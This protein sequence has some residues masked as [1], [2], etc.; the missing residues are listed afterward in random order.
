MYNLAQLKKYEDVNEMINNVN[1]LPRKFSDCTGY[2]DEKMAKYFGGDRALSEEKVVELLVS[3]SFGANSILYA[4]WLGYLMGM[5]AM[6]IHFAWCMSFYLL[7]KFSKQI[8]AHTSIHDFLSCHFGSVAKKVAAI[9]SCI[10]LL[11]FA[12]WEIAIAKSGLDS[13]TMNSEIGK[14]WVW[15]LLLLVMICI[16]LLYTV[17]GGQ[18]ANGYVNL[19]MNR[20]KVILL[21]V[22]GLGIFYA[23]SNNNQ[24]TYDILMP[25]FKDA[26]KSIGLTGLITNIFINLS[27]QFVDNSSWQIIS[28]GC[29]AGMG[30][31][32]TSLKRTGLQIFLIYA[33][34]TFLGASLRGISGLDSDNVLSGIVYIVGGQGNIFF[35]LCI[36]ILLLLSM[37]SLIDGM[38]LSVAQTIMVDLN[39]G[40][41]IKKIKQNRQSGVRTAR[42]IT[43]FLG[44]LAA[45][46]I[47]FALAGF[48][49]SIFDFVYV[50]TIVQLSL[51]GPII[52]GLV[53]QPRCIPRMWISIVISMTLGFLFNILGN[54]YSISWLGDV[55][56]TVTAISSFAISGL[57]LIVSRNCKK[58]GVSQHMGW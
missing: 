50:F 48:G 9:C 13:F 54:V 42:I 53:F 20:I 1:V 30:T 38:S 18:R 14:S 21:V 27:W 7:A 39:F 35:V 6:I 28:S 15:S 41:I 16:A 45:W 24:F 47:Q 44:V 32:S 22:I 33:V 8:Y 26:L 34:E 36:V 12:G 5:W 4:V 58:Q 51:I 10:G 3:T 11:Y 56:G 31:S 43:L 40:E 55:A 49:K 17:I 19:I 46:G 29:D 2:L 25:D 37:M 23:L 57:L 52:I